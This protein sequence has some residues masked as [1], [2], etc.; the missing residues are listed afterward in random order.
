VSTK[1]PFHNESA[2]RGCIGSILLEPRMLDEMPAELLPESF[3]DSTLGTFLRVMR[4]FRDAGKPVDVISVADEFDKRERV[5]GGTESLLRELF[6]AVP[7]TASAF[8]Y[9]KLVIE[10]WKRRQA[11]AAIEQMRNSVTD[12]TAGID[13]T[14]GLCETTLTQL[15]ESCLPKT[16]LSISDMLADALDPK[17]RC[18]KGADTGFDHLD[19]MTTGM[20]AG[21]LLIVAA[22]T[23]IGKSA[24]VGNIAQNL[25][26]RGDGVLLVTLEMSKTDFIYRLAAGMT[27]LTLREI[28]TEKIEVG[29]R[30]LEAFTYMNSWPLFIDD[31]VPQTVAQIAAK[32]RVLV[33]KHRI[34]LVVVDYL[35]LI[36]ASDRRAPREQQI[37]GISRDLKLMAKQ[38][39]LPVIALSQLNRQVENRATKM[40]QLSDIRESGAVE[41]DADGIWML[42]RPGFGD[43]TRDATEAELLVAKNRQGPTGMI[44]MTWDGVRFR[45]REI[46]P[47]EGK[48]Q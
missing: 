27:G 46:D 22:R 38:L 13:E 40:P 30:L 10:C 16:Q 12:P 1:N 37:A 34:R 23:T 33:R 5:T 6:E 47:M 35:Q 11:L 21:Q 25:V 17:M 29:E 3:Y 24:F 14:L 8:Y 7:T 9:A 31:Q 18:A 4:E 20:H 15:A 44:K 42:H 19:L 43:S 39:R 2:E 26:E 36:Q 28:R 41:Q 48:F 32:A 45:Y